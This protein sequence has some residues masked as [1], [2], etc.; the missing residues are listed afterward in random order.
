[1]AMQADISLAVIIDG[2]VVRPPKRFTFA[3]LQQ[4]MVIDFQCDERRV[5]EIFRLVEEHGT[6]RMIGRN[7][8][9]VYLITK[10]L[11]S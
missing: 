7:S 5:R 8:S 6:C 9:E 10:I 2:A 3:E 4:C 1:M 11:A